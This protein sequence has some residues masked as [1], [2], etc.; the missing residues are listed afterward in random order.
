MYQQGWGT[1][2]D[3][4]TTQPQVLTPNIVE[5]QQLC[6]ALHIELPPDPS[7]DGSSASLHGA[8][9]SHNAPASYERW[10]PAVEGMARELGN[11]TIVLKGSEDIVSNGKETCV[12]TE[13]GG[14]RRSGGQGDV[15]AGLVALMCAWGR[16]PVQKP[17]GFS[18]SSEAGTVAE[19]DAHTLTSP[20]LWG[21]YVACFVTKQASRLAFAA[22]GRSMVRTCLC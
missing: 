4:Q 13:P 10:I 22:K 15:L 17:V 3:V 5:F 19:A 8:P 18:P 2:G 7:S 11:V 6:H 21:A 20:L 14:L 12:V 1:H 9:H 16:M